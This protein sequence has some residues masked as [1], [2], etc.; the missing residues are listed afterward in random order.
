MKRRF[1]L[2]LAGAL[3]ALILL[4]LPSFLLN[5]HR[6]LTAAA[7]TASNPSIT[8]HQTFSSFY[9]KLPN[10]YVLVFHTGHTKE[11]GRTEYVT[12]SRIGDEFSVD[13]INGIGRENVKQLTGLA[14]KKYLVNHNIDLTEFDKDLNDE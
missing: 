7:Q 11:F 9:R 4:C 8:T 10:G 12:I 1:Y 5:P 13:L 2:Y 14:A 6:N 3:L